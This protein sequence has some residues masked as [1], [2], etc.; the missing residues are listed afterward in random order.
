R[1]LRD[2]RLDLALRESRRMIPA[3]RGHT[4]DLRRIVREAA[5]HSGAAVVLRRRR[6]KLKRRPLVVLAD[7]SGSMELYSRILL[8][9]LPGLAR[10]RLVPETFVFGT[11]L[12]RITGQ[13]Q[14]RDVD[15][16]LDHAARAI[17]DFAGGTRIGASLAAFN[18]HHAR[19]V[20]RGG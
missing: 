14:I 12:T 3:R 6:R 7:I 11:R 20:L 15:P 13:L 16:A 1:V 9:S 10:L 5:R 8:Q 2:V 19:R 18:R 17:V 4:F